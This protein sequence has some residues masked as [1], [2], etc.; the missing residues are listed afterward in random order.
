MALIRAYLEKFHNAS[1]K[2]TTD[3]IEQIYSEN[4]K[5]STVQASLYSTRHLLHKDQY[6]ELKDDINQ[7]LFRDL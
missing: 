2:S 7:R 5:K 4:L 1:D 6:S 3:V